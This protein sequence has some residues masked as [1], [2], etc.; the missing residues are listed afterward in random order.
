MSKT[1]L[2]VGFGKIGKAIK[3]I[4][5]DRNLNFIIIDKNN[6]NP[7]GLPDSQTF[8]KIDFLFIGLPSWGIRSG[9]EFVAPK[10]HYKTVI[11]SL[12]K[13]IDS[14]TFFFANQLLEEMIPQNKNTAILSGPMLSDELMNNLPTKAIVATS[15]KHT[16]K[17]INDLFKDT[18]LKIE[19][20]EDVLG[21]SLNGVLKNIYA[22]IL[23][24]IDGLELGSNFKGYITTQILSEMS[25]IT[26]YLGADP[27]TSYSVAGIGDLIATGFSNK[28]RNYRAGLEI[29]KFGSTQIKCEGMASLKPLVEIIKNKIEELPLLKLAADILIT[30]AVAPANLKKS[31]TL[32]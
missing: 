17:M 11:I 23:G 15:N 18:L 12:T 10:I 29:S 32:V 28:S 1:C 3:F 19:Y 4:L 30:D 21:V 20:S 27:K 6:N 7:L 13:G 9:L 5:E 25:K 16:Y 26:F 2:I 14:Q 24:T 31:F 22:F 8:S